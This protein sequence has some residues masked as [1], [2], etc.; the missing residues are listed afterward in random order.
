MQ[1]FHSI[2]HKNFTTTRTVLVHLSLNHQ[3]AY[4][5]R[6]ILIDRQQEKAKTLLYK[7]YHKTKKLFRMNEKEI[8]NLYNTLQNKQ[9]KELSA[10]NNDKFCLS[11]AFSSKIFL[12]APPN[13]LMYP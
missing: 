12:S 11:Y 13:Q 5:M 3:Y 6:A 4:D 2:W 9:H 8:N 7:Q 10:Y 1:C